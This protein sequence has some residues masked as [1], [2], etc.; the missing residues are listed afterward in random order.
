ML[1]CAVDMRWKPGRSMVRTGLP[2][3]TKIN[4]MR[5]EEFRSSADGDVIGMGLEVLTLPVRDDDRSREFHVDGFGF[6]LDIDSQPS[7]AFRGVHVRPPGPACSI[8]FGVGLADAPPG[9]AKTNYP[10]GSDLV[11][12]RNELIERRVAVGE[13]RHKTPL[14]DWQGA[15][16]SGDR[17]QS[18]GSRQLR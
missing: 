16:V 10:V 8:Q 9:S 12:A 1:R 17:A 2:A 14:G 13:I 3:D 11:A 7:N 5:A 15:W 18:A 6:E 4:M